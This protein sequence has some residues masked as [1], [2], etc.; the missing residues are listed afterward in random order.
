MI[1]ISPFLVLR[2]VVQGGPHVF[3]FQI[4][5]RKLSYHMFP[6]D[7]KLHRSIS[8]PFLISHAFHGQFRVEVLTFSLIEMSEKLLG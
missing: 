2:F 1:L 6:E 4:T 5:C 7:V 8:I 3:D